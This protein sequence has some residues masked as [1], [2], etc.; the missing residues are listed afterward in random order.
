M[1]SPNVLRTLAL[2]VTA[3]NGGPCRPTTTSAGTTVEVTSTATV[4]GSTTDLTSTIIE[5]AMETETTGIPTLATPIIGESTTTDATSTT[6]SAA[7]GD[8][9]CSDDDGCLVNP[10]LCVVNRL[11]VCSCVDAICQKQIF[12]S[13]V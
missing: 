8:T 1:L 6:T 10:Q 4:M 13:A 9:P 5:S 12:I 2:L 7:I 11:N 3:V